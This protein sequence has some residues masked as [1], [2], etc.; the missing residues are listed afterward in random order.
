MLHN[1]V[2]VDRDNLR[3]R[4][5]NWLDMKGFVLN[6]FNKNKQKCVKILIRFFVFEILVLRLA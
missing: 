6:L 3:L 2:D 4:F 5:H 1:I